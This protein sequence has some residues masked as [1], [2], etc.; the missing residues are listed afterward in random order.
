MTD[1][2]TPRD[3]AQAV[4]GT[5]CWKGPMPLQRYYLRMDEP[6]SYRTSEVD[7]LVADLTARIQALEAER[8]KWLGAFNRSEQFQSGPTKR[9]EAA[10]AER[11]RLRVVA[12]HHARLALEAAKD[13]EGAVFDFEIPEHERAKRLG[14]WHSVEGTRA[15]DVR[16][17]NILKDEP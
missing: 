16:I 2:P 5:T 8:D 9:A 7:A 12:F 11:D 3:E 17:T 1:Q 15:T 13:V 14:L 10:E 6:P 4:Q